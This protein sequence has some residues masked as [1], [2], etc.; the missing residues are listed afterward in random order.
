LV[1]ALPSLL[2]QPQLRRLLALSQASQNRFDDA[3][4]TLRDDKSP[5]NRLLAAEMAARRDN[6]EA[7][8]IVEDIDVIGQDNLVELKWR[9][10]G[11]LALRVG[12]YE[13]VDSA[14]VALSGQ[15]AGRLLADLLRLRKDAQLDSD[16]KERHARLIAIASTEFTL[17]NNL[18]RY[19]VAEEMRNQGLPAEA[20]KLVEPIIDLQTLNPAT[21]LYLGCLVEARRDEAF[22]LS[23]AKAC[24]DIQK[25]PEILWLLA[26]HSWNVGDL[27]EARRAVDALL[28]DQPNSG[29]ARLLRIEILLRSDDIDGL[30]P[31]LARPIERL[32]FVRLRDKFRLA[33]LLGHFGHM[34]RAVA[35]AYRLFLENREISQAWLCFEGLILLERMNHHNHERSWDP[36]V[37]GDDAA[38]DIDYEDGTKQFIIVEPDGMLRRLDSDSWEPKHLLVQTIAGLEVGSQFV[39]PANAIPGT[40][41]QIRHKYVAKHHFVLTNHETRFPH[42][43]AFRSIPIDVSTPDGLAPLLEE[44]KAKHDWVEQEQDNY[45]KGPSPLALFAHRIGTD[46]IDVA[47]GLM[48]QE[49]PLKVAF[50]SQAER[51]TAMAAIASNGAAGC[52]LDLLAYWTCWRLGALSPLAEVCG[53]IHISQSTMDQLQARRERISQ[54]AR[55][56]IK[57]ARY[58]DGKMAITEVAPDAVQGWLAEVDRAIEW[59]RTNAV[60]CPLIVPEKTPEVLRDFLRGIPQ[61]FDSLVLAMQKDFLLITDDLPTRDFGR[62]FGFAQSAWL[63]PVFMVAGNKHKIDFDTYVKWTAHLI[64][65]GYN[66]VCVSG[67]VLIRATSID[68]EGSECPGYYVKQIVKMIGGTAA[69]PESHIRVVVEFLRH[70]WNDSSTLGYREQTTSLL[71]ENLIRE[72]T[73]DYRRILRTIIW[74][75]PD[76]PTLTKYLTGWLRGHFIDLRA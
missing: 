30:L 48:A 33:S 47:E 55:T 61:I 53:T 28:S 74:V 76:I 13:R 44:L 71:L 65:V 37:V 41:R 24:P 49:Q 16:E 52:V 66:Y 25:D 72:R 36:K 5:E 19:L 3:E 10:L 50:G 38:V 27:P 32:M 15:P 35:Y 43:S 7:I 17:T 42:V 59:A 40:I 26:S 14:I 12:D 58:H 8:K 60:V 67:G 9:I 6:K 34:D 68:L 64:S 2:D 62:H 22:R 57:S 29:T 21:R 4:A 70:V 1:R 18:P 46:T 39:N 56:G 73:A 23:L 31:E 69:E 45:R 63:Q 54:S 20:A 75:V 51:D 11:D